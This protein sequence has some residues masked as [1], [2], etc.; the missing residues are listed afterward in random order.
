MTCKMCERKK[1]GTTWTRDILLGVKTP[2]QAAEYF[3]MTVQEVTTH[4]NDHE[5][6]LEDERS[7]YESKDFYVRELAR[8]YALAKDWLT[9]VTD[10]REISKDQIDLGIK[11]SKEIRATIT[12]LAEFQGRLDK[13]GNV[14]AKM[15]HIEAKYIKLTTKIVTEVCPECQQKILTVIESMK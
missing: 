1:D 15:E 13:G 10:A 11:L 12:A 3:D 7:I 4:V 6:L 14:V 2:A 8:L 9:Y 5:F